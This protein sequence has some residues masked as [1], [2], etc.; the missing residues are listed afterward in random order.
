VKE[1]LVIKRR[2]VVENRV[3]DVDLRSERVDVDRRGAGA[4]P[5]D[6]DERPDNP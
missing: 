3:I 4:P 1:V 5:R 6:S 2:R